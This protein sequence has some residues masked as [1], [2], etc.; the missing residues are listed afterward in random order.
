[1]A[2]LEERVAADLELGRHGEL[3]ASCATS[4]AASRCASVCRRS[5]SGRFTAR[6][7]PRPWRRTSR[8]GRR[9]STVWESSR[10]RAAGA[11]RGILSQD[12]K[13]EPGRAGVLPSCG[14]GTFWSGP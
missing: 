3:V 6:P 11:T 12:E 8:R 14:R 13:L 1:M 9:W 2:A 10:P 5:S 7:A 4:L